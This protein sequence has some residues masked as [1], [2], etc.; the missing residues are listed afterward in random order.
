MMGES[1]KRGP[2][3]ES[4]SIDGPW[5]SAVSKALKKKRPAEG[6]PKPEA[7][8]KRKSKPRKKKQG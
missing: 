5:E 7:K 3:P 4:V 8:K 2:A 6:W 1:K